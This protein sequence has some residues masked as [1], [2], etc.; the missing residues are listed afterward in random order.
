[1]T[2]PLDPMEQQSAGFL[3]L[4]IGDPNRSVTRHPFAGSC[5]TAHVTED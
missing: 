3:N 2:K 1:M 5:Y 4:A